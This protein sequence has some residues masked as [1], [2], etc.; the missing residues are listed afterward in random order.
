MID[1][2]KQQL[3]VFGKDGKQKKMAENI[4]KHLETLVKKQALSIGDFPPAIQVKG[5]LTTYKLDEFKVFF[6]SKLFF[7]FPFPFFNPPSRTCIT[8]SLKSS[9]LSSPGTSP[10]Y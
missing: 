10:G 5:F 3:P 7:F 9:T 2:F 4:Q 8:A 6:L 1:D